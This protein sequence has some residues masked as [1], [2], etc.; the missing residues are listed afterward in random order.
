MAHWSFASKTKEM[1]LDMMSRV[2]VSHIPNH[3][4]YLFSH[5]HVTKAE[6][7]ASS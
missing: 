5:P 6:T 1:E 4:K 3:F 2:K 7:Q